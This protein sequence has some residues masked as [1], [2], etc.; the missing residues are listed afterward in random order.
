ML[1]NCNQRNNRKNSKHYPSWDS[2]F[3]FTY[4]QPFHQLFPVIRS[5]PTHCWDLSLSNKLVGMGEEIPS[6]F[7]IL[8]D[9]IIFTELRGAGMQYMNSILFPIC[10]SFNPLVGHPR[11]SIGKL[12]NWQP[13]DEV[14]TGNAV[15]RKMVLTL[16]RMGS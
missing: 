14:L 8:F 6:L 1:L 15:K 4:F 10:Y 5:N 16:K 2:F 12:I 3:N 7:V 13:I 9:R 11:L